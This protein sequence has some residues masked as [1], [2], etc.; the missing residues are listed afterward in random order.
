MGEAHPSSAAWRL[1]YGLRD[2]PAQRSEH[3]AILARWFYSKPRDGEIFF[4]EGDWPYRRIL[5]A[6]GRLLAPPSSN[7]SAQSSA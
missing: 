4:R 3:L 2:A 1:E 6:C 5:R 7:P